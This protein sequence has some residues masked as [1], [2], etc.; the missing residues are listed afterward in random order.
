[1]DDDVDAIAELYEAVG[2]AERWRRV[3]ERLAL[4]RGH[5]ADIE[6]H[7]ETARRLHEQ[8]AAL[9]RE[10]EALWAV[11]DQLPLGAL[12]VDRESRVLRANATATRLLTGGH[13]LHLVADRLHSADADADARLHGAIARVAVGQVDRGDPDGPFLVVRR[14]GRQPLAVLVLAARASILHV[15]EGHLPVVLLVLDPDVIGAPGTEVLCGIFGFTPREAEFAG[16][17]LQGLNVTEAAQALGV[18]VATAR[19]F[20]AHVTA[21]TDSHSQA[22]L[23]RRLL[24]I[25]PAV[26]PDAR[27]DPK[28]A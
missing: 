3:T 18:T 17:M 28:Q 14:P 2:D 11:H 4:T 21:K 26:R 12:V 13:G 16:L 9:S 15:F 7:V 8:H 27:D 5:S 6:Q 20:L 22:E 1:M 25:P 10:I 24:A 23:V 19:T